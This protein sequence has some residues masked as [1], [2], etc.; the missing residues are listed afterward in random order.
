MPPNMSSKSVKSCWLRCEQLSKC[1]IDEVIIGFWEVEMV[2]NSVR[3]EALRTKALQLLI[4]LRNASQGFRAPFSERRAALLIGDM[5]LVILSTLGAFF[6]WYQTANSPFDMGH[7]VQRWYWFPLLV[8]SW[9]A[10][11]WLNDLYD[12]RSSTHPVLSTF[13]IFT[14]I[15]LSI[16][17]YLFV[18]FL[19]PNPNSLPRL[20]FLYH[21]LLVMPMMIFWRWLYAVMFRIFPMPHK[22]LIVGG[23]IRASVIA[24][25]LER[26]P[27]INYQVVGYV[28]DHH[29]VQ[30]AAAISN[31]I[32]LGNI[33]DLPRLASKLSINEVVIAV[34]REIDK[35]ILQTLIDCHGR[36]V[37][38]SNMP[39]LYE[40]LQNRIPVEHIDPLWVLTVMERLPNRMQLFTKRLM[41]L[42]L[43]FLG[44]LV[45]VSCLPVIA[46][47]IRL[48][49]PGPVFYRQKRSGRSGRH[50]SIFKFRTMTIDAEQDGVARWATSSDVR[51]TR[52]GRILRKTRLDELPQVINILRGEMSV[53]GPRPERPEF[54]EEL[55]QEIPYYRTRLMVKPGLT[56]WAQ[57]HYD[58]GNSVEDALIKLHYD[59]YYLRYWSIWLD[60][61]TIFRT[62]G[63]MARFK[64]T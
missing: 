23:D 42:G 7:M 61:Y 27:E 41:D 53:V 20:F 34:E 19:T 33:A 28:E 3:Q 17:I 48:D 6:L 43:G 15:L 35:N 50:F 57:V 55:Q 63:V 29:Q 54:V 31:L 56:G 46:L 21:L 11:A 2:G 5:I 14:V 40:K 60:L 12:V 8:V 49:S 64:G 4:R 37:Q 25:V 10:L 47:A 13:R 45:L 44:L 9:W 1:A 62:V 38:I 39:D 58:Y 22:V 18:F 26:A 16:G 24:R 59:F 30:E 51:I 32:H 36:G 52:V